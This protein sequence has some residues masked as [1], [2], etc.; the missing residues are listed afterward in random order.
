[1]D[2]A[3]AEHSS[4]DGRMGNKG[5][6]TMFLANFSPAS[7]H[8]TGCYLT[9]GQMVKIY[10][11]RPSLKNTRNILVHRSGLK[12]NCADLCRASNAVDSKWTTKHHPLVPRNSWNT[13]QPQNQ[14]L[15]ESSQQRQM[16]TKTKEISKPSRYSKTAENSVF[17][18]TF[19]AFQKWYQVFIGEKEF[20]CNPAA[21][22]SADK[23]SNGWWFTAEDDRS[24]SPTLARPTKKGQVFKS[25]QVTDFPLFSAKRWNELS[26]SRGS[27]RLLMKPKRDKN[28]TSINI[29]KFSWW[30]DDMIKKFR[31]RTY[32]LIQIINI[33]PS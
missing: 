11:T 26:S 17:W 18:H 25:L 6:P 14:W 33:F 4:V 28:W 29:S 15:F 19:S 13:E 21:S 27:L 32:K 10:Q 22:A 12:M 24:V 31:W 2:L 5:E 8:S 16:E 30:Q 1:M 9:E 20:S 3:G 7:K 23:T